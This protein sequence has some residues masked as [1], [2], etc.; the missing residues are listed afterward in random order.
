MHA[1]NTRVLL[2]SN[3]TFRSNAFD[4]L[5]T[6]TKKLSNLERSDKSVG[7]AFRL[8]KTFSYYRGSLTHCD[9]APVFDAF[10]FWQRNI[11]RTTTETRKE[12]RSTKHP[13]GL[14]TIREA[15]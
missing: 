15:T 3:L 11:H 14:I 8:K 6:K 4:L 13:H 9:S 5:Y 2:S 10:F 7:Q 12:P 1:S